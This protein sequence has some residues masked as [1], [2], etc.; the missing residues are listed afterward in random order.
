MPMMMMPPWECSAQRPPGP[1][2]PWSERGGPVMC[3]PGPPGPPAGHLASA[4]CDN[5]GPWGCGAACFDRPLP[6]GPPFHGHA[7]PFCAAPHGPPGPA[8]PAYPGPGWPPEACAQGHS[9]FQVGPGHGPMPSMSVGPGP[10]EE[11]RPPWQHGPG[12]QGCTVPRF[13]PDGQE[14]PLQ[15]GGVMNPGPVGSSWSTPRRPRGPPRMPPGGAMLP[16]PHMASARPP[17]GPLPA[18]GYTPQRPAAPMQIVRHIQ[19]VQDAEVLSE[20]SPEWAGTKAAW[21]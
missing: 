12:V 3:P 19:A 2:G 8:Y 16:G 15:P 9:S 11:M 20:A 10:W 1:P 5:F 21:P 18:R 14:L 4:G 17:P 7:P 6:R 13:G